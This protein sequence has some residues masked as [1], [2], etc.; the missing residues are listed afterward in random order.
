MRNLSLID[1]IYMMIHSPW[2]CAT[3]FAPHKRQDGFALLL[4]LLF[5][6]MVGVALMFF[7]R[8]NARNDR[9]QVYFALGEQYAMVARAMHTY[10]QEHAYFGP[11]VNNAQP[12]DIARYNYFKSIEDTVIATYREPL[13]SQS[14]PGLN[15]ITLQDLYQPITDFSFLDRS[16]TLTRPL[17][18][19]E[20]TFRGHGGMVPMGLSEKVQAASSLIVMYGR[21]VGSLPDIR[22]AA[23]MAAFRAGAAANGFNR[24]GIV[25]PPSQRS[26]LMC[27]GQQAIVKWGNNEND[28]LSEAEATTIGMS[29]DTFDVVAPAWESVEKQLSLSFLYRRPHPGISGTN[30]MYTDLKMNPSNHNIA[31]GIKDAVEIYTQT[32]NDEGGTYDAA[33][34]N[35][36]IGAI[37]PETGAIDT[38]VTDTA[39][40]TVGYPQG[41]SSD[42]QESICDNTKVRTCISGEVDITGDLAASYNPTYNNTAPLGPDE[43]PEILTVAGVT[44]VDTGSVTVT[45]DEAAYPERGFFDVTGGGGTSTFN[46]N[47]QDASG[48]GGMV[49]NEKATLGTY[50]INDTTNNEF[51]IVD[52]ELVI[53]GGNISVGTDGRPAQFALTEAKLE[54]AGAPIHIDTT[55]KGTGNGVYS[56][57]TQARALEQTGSTAMAFDNIML[58]PSPSG[59]QPTLSVT[60]NVNVDPNGMYQNYDCVGR[61]CPDQVSKGPNGSPF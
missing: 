61:A 4:T 11:Y 31:H 38:S 29:L 13:G 25:L 33:D 52:K 3:S 26:S 39:M 56:G 9:Y 46:I 37:D 32:V 10:V 20:Y 2:A 53:T 23:D 6:G 36:Y 30:V 60:G 42:R 1:L 48:D 15:I 8:G 27:R 43:I 5:V 18:G 19:I 14:N 49:I 17:R 45:A 58:A 57:E 51:F 55:G 34:T 47:K 40:L 28:C 54:T 35:L 50:N 16:M 44:K 22:T 12:A 24:I 21:P 59:Q 7:Y 41:G